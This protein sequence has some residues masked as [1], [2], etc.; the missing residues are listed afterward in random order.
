MIENFHRE[1]FADTPFSDYYV[2]KISIAKFLFP[3]YISIGESDFSCSVPRWPK[4]VPQICIHCNSQSAIYRVQNNM[5]NGKSRHIHCKH[6]TIRQL[7]STR[8]ISLDYVRSKDNIANMLT[9]GIS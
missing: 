5:Y 1:T 2:L 7:L 8:V 3:Q 6:N 9:K 4:H